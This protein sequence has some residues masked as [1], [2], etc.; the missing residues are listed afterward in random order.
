MNSI[1]GSFVFV[2]DR[3]TDQAQGISG[4]G[5]FGVATASLSSESR[6]AAGLEPRRLRIG[7]DGSGCMSIYD[8]TPLLGSPRAY[9]D[10][11]ST[12]ERTPYLA[13]IRRSDFCG[14]QKASKMTTATQLESIKD[15]ADILNV[16]PD[17]LHAWRK[18]GYVLTVQLPN[19]RHVIP[20]SELDRLLAGTSTTER[21]A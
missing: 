15:S 18:R 2:L 17:T 13:T 20:R 21:T 10:Q 8:A 4:H 5:S 16:H 11:E 9:P 12:A 19:G 1:V 14:Q 3:P 7:V 6:K